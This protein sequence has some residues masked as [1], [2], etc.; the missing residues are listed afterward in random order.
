M[1]KYPPVAAMNA[2]HPIDNHEKKDRRE[3]S[4]PASALFKA[5]GGG[6]DG[7]ILTVFLSVAFGMWT[8][9]LQSLVMLYEQLLEFS[10]SNH[11]LSILIMIVLNQNFESMVQR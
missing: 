5:A 6:L 3:T 9:I 11:F 2:T 4:E 1:V 8:S 10:N 7:L